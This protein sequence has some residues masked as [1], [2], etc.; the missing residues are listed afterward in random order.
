MLVLS[1]ALPGCGDDTGAATD[2]NAARAAVD[3]PLATAE[4][5][6][7]DA[8]AIRINERGDFEP[9]RTEAALAYITARG[10]PPSA[11]ALARLDQAMDELVFS[12]IQK[13]VN[14]DPYRPRVYWV[15][16]Q[17]RNWF[18]LTVPGS[19]YSYD[20]PDNIYRIIPI[21][22]GLRYELRGQRFSPGPSDVT[23]SLISNASS[24]NTVDFLDGR[25]LVLNP[26][27]SYVIRIDSDPADGRAN[28]LRATSQVVQLFVR[29]N[30]GDWRRETPDQLSVRRVDN[31]PDAAPP[32]E[33]DI[34]L[35]AYSALQQAVLFYGVGA[36]G[37]KTSTNPVNTLPTPQQSST[38]GTLVSQASAFGHFALGEGEVLLIRLRRGGARYFVVPVTDPWM[39]T[40]DPAR[41]QS[42]LN[43]AQSLPDADGGY[44]FVV[45]PDDPGVANW[46]DTA[47]L[48]EGTIM[49]RWQGLPE[50]VTDGGPAVSAQK[51]RLSDLPALLPAGTRRVTVAERARQIDERYQGYLRRVSFTQP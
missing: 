34:T 41:H 15:N 8:L 40:V 17:P 5:R 20:N 36:L 48:R 25:D 43:Q 3:N 42:S 38:L 10:T 31:L 29:N 45:S 1:V 33:R 4:Q 50:T 44:T 21:D 49:V 7:L 26:D 13:V 19:R 12:A 16:A 37:V 30:L 23:F 46:L 18:G 39:I 11:E 47:G 22:G 2:G 35:Q 6:D 9:L 24:Q 32:G 14:G 51:V 28:H 27:G